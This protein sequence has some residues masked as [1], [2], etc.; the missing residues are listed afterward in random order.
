MAIHVNPE[1]KTGK[2]VGADRCKYKAHNESQGVP[3]FDTQAE[4]DA[5][6]Q[7][8]DK[9]K[10]DTGMGGLSKNNTVEEVEKI[11][12]EEY[13]V[14]YTMVDGKLEG[15]KKYYPTRV[16][17]GMQGIDLQ[18]GERF[19][20]TQSP[21]LVENYKNGVLH[22]ENGKPAVLKRATSDFGS[23]GKVLEESYYDNGKLHRADGKPAV[24][25]YDDKGKPRE[26]S[27]YENGVLHR[28]DG[29]PAQTLYNGSRKEEKYVVGGETTQRRRSTRYRQNRQ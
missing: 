10:Y 11:G 17:L 3:H 26:E 28:A 25:K 23:E 24:L 14:E 18:S 12:G 20:A 9:R 16:E 27:Y 19:D 4:A 7:A 5:Y 21:V 1:G 13:R 8:E 6:V 2:C 22:S 15:E 29:N